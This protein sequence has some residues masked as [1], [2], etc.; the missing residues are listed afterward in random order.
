MQGNWLVNKS[1]KNTQCGGLIVPYEIWT[2]FV[3]GAF[4]R[5]IADSG[6]SRAG[7]DSLSWVNRD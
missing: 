7:D 2:F 3:S 4:G 1:L 6:S 5:K